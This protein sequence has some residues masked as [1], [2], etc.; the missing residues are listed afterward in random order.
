MAN[1]ENLKRTKKEVAEDVL[2]TFLQNLADGFET[3]KKLETEE[4]VEFDYGRYGR[5]ICRRAVN[6]NAAYSKALRE[7]IVPYIEARG[8]LP[9]GGD[10]DVA[11]RKM[12]EVYVETIIF[13]LKTPDGLDIPY[14]ERAK[15]GLI[16]VFVKAPDLFARLQSDV[17]SA[18]NF[19]KKRAEKE[20][21]N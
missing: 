19:R 10:D 16:E 14:D 18:A 8:D 17:S 21:K 1:T 9:E 11:N 12:A 6:R 5:F 3:D 4:G 7:K 15:A 2:S 13:G 20:L